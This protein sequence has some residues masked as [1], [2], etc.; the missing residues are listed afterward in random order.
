MKYEIAYMRAP[1][2]WTP[3]TQSFGQANDKDTARALGYKYVKANANKKYTAKVEITQPSLFPKKILIGEVA[4]YSGKI[5][6]FH[7][8]SGTI[9]EIDRYGKLGKRVGKIY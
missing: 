9:T 6:Y 7:E 5:C 2:M 1:K 4:Y 8:K 3:E